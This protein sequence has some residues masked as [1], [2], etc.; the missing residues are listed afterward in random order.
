MILDANDSLQLLLS[1]ATATTPGDLF[2]SYVEMASDGSTFGPASASATTNGTT[3]VTL[4]SAA[5]TGKV[6]QVKYL[7]IYNADTASIT[8]TVRVVDNATNRII[9]KITLAT[10]ERAAYMDGNGFTA[11]TADGAA[12][13]SAVTSVNGDTGPVIVTVPI[14][15]AC[16]DE[17]TALT[18]G[19]AKATFRTPYAMTLTEIPRA[20]VTTAPTGSVL[21]VDI[22]E[23]GASILSTKL[24][25]DA[26]E[27]TSTTAAIPAV[28][29][30]A[31]LANDA[32]ITIDIDGVGSTIAGAGLKV[33]LIG[34]AT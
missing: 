20:S 12:K 16:S 34:Y 10:G 11:Y 5:G 1:G 9:T 22:N 15:I 8:V 29:S 30:D 26:S 33:T 23:G 17:T 2:A 27:K 3:A 31:T 6:R 32:E 14:I 19:T 4:V 18:T 7:S 25:I 13:G 28:L 21:T 24:T